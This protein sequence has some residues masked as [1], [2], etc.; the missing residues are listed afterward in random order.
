MK[1]LIIGLLLVCII[2]GAVA[3]GAYEEA[4][5]SI[6]T[7]TSPGKES[8]QDMESPSF[9]PLPE[10]LE[11]G[12][13]QPWSS[14]RMIIRNGYLTLV[15]EDVAGTI[16][17]I[18]R[19]AGSYNGFVV[20][21]NSWQERGRTMGDITIRV[22]AERFD[23]AIRTLSDMAVE[24]KRESTSGQDVTEE[25]VDLESR[26][27]NLEVSKARLLELME[28]AG[29]V[30]E[31]L[32]VEI[33]LTNTGSEI[34]QIKG[35]MQYLEQSSA[36]SSIQVTLEQSELT[37]EFTA[38]SR[39]VREGQKVRFFPEISGGFS[40]YSYE[41]D[42]GDG[43]TS[44]AEEPSHAY[45]KD[46]SFTVKLNITDDRGNIA[47]YERTD[48]VTISPGWSPG[49]IASA[50][51]NGLVAFFR[52]LANIIIWLGIFSP[53]W[54]I[55]LVILYFTWWRRRK[56]TSEVRGEKAETID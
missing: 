38:D 4:T 17:Q 5:M 52:V 1:R 14:D 55:I 27:K 45:H 26:L 11:N 36:L 16:E 18:A 19:I 25:Y 21:S 2:I 28:K 37:V 39:N 29:T 42:F 13:D 43:N 50:A 48:Y 44:N 33:E 7:T 56:K 53:L 41:W 3:C 15:V 8:N 35:R 31:I 9:A 20:S 12:S 54:I 23:E 10:L 40:P 22:D 49:N 32:K 51:W 47:S 46:G 30:E 34:E 24:V 6:P